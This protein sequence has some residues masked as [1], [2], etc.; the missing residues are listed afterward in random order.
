MPHRF[1]A[2][3]AVLAS[4]ALA[5]A[6]LVASQGPALATA[7]PSPGA[8][9]AAVADLASTGARPGTQVSGM[10]PYVDDRSTGASTV[11]SYYNALHRQEY[12]RA[13]S[14]WAPGLVVSRIGDYQSFKAGFA[15]TEAFSAVL[16]QTRVDQGAGQMY[17]YVPVALTALQSDGSTRAYSICFA[18]HLASPQIQDDP[19][20][21]PWAIESAQIF[22]LPDGGNPVGLLGSA[23]AGKGF[24]PPSVSPA[25]NPNDISGSRYLDDRSTPEEVLRSLFNAVNRKEY[26][27]AYSY[28]EANAIGPYATFAAGY[29]DTASVNLTI[30]QTRMGAAAG[31]LYFD[32]P[33]T[34]VAQNTRLGTQTYVGCY[35]LHLSQPAIQDQPPY[36]PLAIRSAS[37]RQVP[38]DASTTALMARACPSN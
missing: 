14:Y 9:P 7:L 21:D 28:W 22:R 8:A 29:A 20:F 33:V 19:P 25:S 4:L 5:L 36:Q 32:V 11:L 2:L 35:T 26:D 34:L 31:Q 38:N 37:V 12:D 15:D 17:N 6:W 1:G 16:G 27:R 13:Y 30:G 23:C 10:P 3:A 18:L 24:V